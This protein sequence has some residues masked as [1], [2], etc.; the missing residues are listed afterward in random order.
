[1]SH[2]V[3][4]VTAQGSFGAAWTPIAANFAYSPTYAGPAAGSGDQGGGG[5]ERAV[6]TARNHAGVDSVHGRVLSSPRKLKLER[7]AGTV[8]VH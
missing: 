6:T 2:T 4:L 8:G 1:V 5:D 3:R 7:R